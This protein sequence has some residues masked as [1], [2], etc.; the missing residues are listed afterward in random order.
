MKAASRLG[1]ILSTMNEAETYIAGLDDYQTE[2][3]IRVQNLVMKELPNVELGYSYGILVFRYNNK[4]LLY[5]GAFKDHLS[6]YPASDAMIQS[7]GKELEPFRS[8]KGT[9]KFT[10]SLPLSD[11]LLNKIVEFFVAGVVN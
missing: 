2:Q 10:K 3:W 5:F 9:L 11:L 6:L 4:P 1:G 8:S 7:I